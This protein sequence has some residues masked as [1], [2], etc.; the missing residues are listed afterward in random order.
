MVTNIASVNTNR[1]YDQPPRGYVSR[2]KVGHRMQ[3]RSLPMP[4]DDIDMLRS[5]HHQQHHPAAVLT[6]AQRYS[7]GVVAAKNVE[8]ERE[9]HEKI[10]CALALLDL[11]T[12]IT[13]HKY[14]KK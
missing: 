4:T 2:W 11:H 1:K 9:F 3:Q 6:Y 10:T 12:A 5:F 14:S 7:Y 8:K 13:F